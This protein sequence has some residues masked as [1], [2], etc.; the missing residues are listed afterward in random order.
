MEQ[1]RV[2][3]QSP[4]RMWGAKLGL[5]IPSAIF[6]LVLIGISASLGTGLVSPALVFFI[7]PVRPSNATLDDV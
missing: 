3:H 7:P 4:K 6:D 1:Q 2:V 5:R